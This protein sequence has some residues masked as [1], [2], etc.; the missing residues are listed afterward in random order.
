MKRLIFL[1]IILFTV[2]FAFAQDKAE[3][4][5]LPSVNVRTL[6]GETFNTADIYNDGNPILI[7]FWALW[8]KPCKNEMDAYNDVCCWLRM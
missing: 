8:C 3:I 1:V 6:E 5:K 7:S 2:S 4:H